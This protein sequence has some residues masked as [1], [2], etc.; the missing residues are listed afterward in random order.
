MENN[1]FIIKFSSVEYLLSILHNGPYSV[2]GALFVLHRW[3]PELELRNLRIIEILVWIN[4][5]SGIPMELIN[6]VAGPKLTSM[7]GEVEEDRT[8]IFGPHNVRYHT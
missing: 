8:G 4:R 6:P 7:I 2:D 1:F 3:E 5:L